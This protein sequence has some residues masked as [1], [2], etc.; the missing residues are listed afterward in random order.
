M[1]KFLLI[2]LLLFLYACTVF[3]AGKVSDERKK[4][5][6]HNNNKEFCE[7]NPD[8]CVNNIPWF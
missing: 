7:K 5:Y 2:A 6:E 3:E 8:K 4:L 1:K